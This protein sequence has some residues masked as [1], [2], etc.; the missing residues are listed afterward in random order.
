MGNRGRAAVGL[1]VLFTGVLIG[2]ALPGLVA[3]GARGAS[4]AWLALRGNQLQED[5]LQ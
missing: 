3:G 5:S 2:L 1:V 4:G